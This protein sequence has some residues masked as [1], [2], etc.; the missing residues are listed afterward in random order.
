M[1]KKDIVGRD[2]NTLLVSFLSSF[3]IYFI[4]FNQRKIFIRVFNNKL[5]NK[6]DRCMWKYD[7]LFNSHLENNELWFL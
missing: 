3:I 5:Y 6:I 1:N 4:K 2:F 7:D